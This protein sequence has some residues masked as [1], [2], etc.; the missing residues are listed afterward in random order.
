[1]SEKNFM[2]AI[3]E[4]MSLWEWLVDMYVANRMSEFCEAGRAGSLST[5]QNAV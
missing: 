5:L 4:V 3:W 1:M 2:A